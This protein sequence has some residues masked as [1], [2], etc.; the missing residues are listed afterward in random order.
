MRMSVNW[1]PVGIKFNHAYDNPSALGG[2]M[3]Q[4]QKNNT[5]LNELM[6]DLVAFNLFIH[7]WAARS[8]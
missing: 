2:L 1:P 7:R 6:F 5:C 3:E 8:C 4:A